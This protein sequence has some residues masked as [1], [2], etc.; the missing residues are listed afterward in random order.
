MQTVLIDTDIAIDY[1][2]GREYARDLLFLLWERETAF[3]SILSVYELYAGMRNNEQED[4]DNFIHACIIE[5]V[6]IEISKKGG[7]LYR[8][9]RSEGITLTSLDCMIN[10]TAS[11]KNHKIATNNTDHYPNKD[12]LIEF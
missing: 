5:P 9:Y 4:T 2:R 6:T 12:I 10:A 3:L 1:L 11:I 7:E 8:K